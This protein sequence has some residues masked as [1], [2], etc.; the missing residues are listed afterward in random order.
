MQGFD[1]KSSRTQPLGRYRRRWEDNT[2][3]I[4]KEYD[5]MARTEFT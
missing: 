4:F 3:L 2:K 5:A 1:W